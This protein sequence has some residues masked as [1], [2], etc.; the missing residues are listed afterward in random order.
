MVEI[1][2]TLDKS[3]HLINSALRYV[4]MGLLFFMMALG[5]CDVLGRYL[6][7]KPILGTLEIFE[8]LLP[9]IVLLGLGYTQGSN[10][11]VRVELF[12][13]HLSLRKQ[14]ILNFITN[15]CTLFISVLILWRGWLLTTEY[16]R[17]GRTIPTI[18][19]PMFLPQLLVPLGALML[20]YVL[21][22]Q[23]VQYII[24][25]SERS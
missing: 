18:E 9:A 25:L 17:I 20:I 14:T 2:K 10:A 12:V 19:V 22:V 23:M 21:I 24:Q 11:H 5:T 6:F 4:C 13:S 15:G 7:N 3:V 16:R 1:A 8:I